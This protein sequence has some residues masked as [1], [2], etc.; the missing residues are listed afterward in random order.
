MFIIFC[1][2]L[3]TDRPE[4]LERGLECKNAET[5]WLGWCMGLWG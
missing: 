2:E 5:D 1:A 3:V 4:A